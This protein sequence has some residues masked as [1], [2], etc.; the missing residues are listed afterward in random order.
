LAAF[1]VASHAAGRKVINAYPVTAG[2]AGINLP[3][4]VADASIVYPIIKF[5]PQARAISL[6]RDMVTSGAVAYMAIQFLN[7]ANS[8]GGA[9]ASVVNNTYV[10]GETYAGT[11][12]VTGGGYNCSGLSG[13]FSSIDSTC[14]N[15]TISYFSG[16]DG[17]P[18]QDRG[19]R[20]NSATSIDHKF[21]RYGFFGPQYGEGVIYYNQTSTSYP[22]GYSQTPVS[23]AQLYEMLSEYLASPPA[24]SNEALWQEMIENDLLRNAAHEPLPLT[25]Q[26]LEQVN[27][28]LRD[29]ISQG[30]DPL[31]QEIAQFGREHGVDGAPDPDTVPEATQEENG[32]VGGGANVTVNVEYEPDTPGGTFTEPQ[33]EELDS[34]AGITDAFMVRIAGAPLPQ[35]FAAVTST[36]P[37]G[38]CPTASVDL[39]EL[40]TH[41]LMSWACPLWAEH[42]APVLSVLMVALWGFIGLRIIFT[43]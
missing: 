34:F 23:D 22:P 28:A 7:Y 6:A 13:T 4:V 11:W 18:T 1:P 15:Q 36:W 20:N 31:A 43:A 27:T 33:L 14:F 35:A 2:P 3:V 16:V 10:F 24:D 21:Q 39:Q 38:S 17:Y 19:L 29:G 37:Q 40:G 9:Q 32:A 12:A 26:Q 41:E 30:M 42:M 5:I 8:Q 25:P